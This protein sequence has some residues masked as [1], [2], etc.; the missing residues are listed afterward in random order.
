MPKSILGAPT[1]SR[2]L[3]PPDNRSGFENPTLERERDTMI[4]SGRRRF[5]ARSICDHFGRPIEWWDGVCDNCRAHERF[6]NTHGRGIS[7]RGVADGKPV[8]YVPN[9]SVERRCR[10]KM[11]GEETN[12]EIVRAVRVLRNMR[13]TF[14]A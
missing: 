5:E 12:I 3:W 14:G 2:R 6:R 1:E 4:T 13:D 10:A 8:T 9:D 11:A 7:K